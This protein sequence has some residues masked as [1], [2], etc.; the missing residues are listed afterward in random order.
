MN[1]QTWKESDVP[2]HWVQMVLDP[3]HHHLES[4]SSKKVESQQDS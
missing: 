3:Y 1:R 2:F 4:E